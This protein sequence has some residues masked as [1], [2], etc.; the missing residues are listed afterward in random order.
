MCDGLGAS[1]RRLRC[2]VGDDFEC[3]VLRVLGA[4]CGSLG[5]S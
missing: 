4:S 1:N 3:D 5:A 2:V